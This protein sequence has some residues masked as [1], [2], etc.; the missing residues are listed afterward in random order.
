MDDCLVKPIERQKLIETVSR[1]KNG[2]RAEIAV[3]KAS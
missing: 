2:G 3:R 1:Y